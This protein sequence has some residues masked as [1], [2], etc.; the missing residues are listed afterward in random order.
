VTGPDGGGTVEEGNTPAWTRLGLS[1]GAAVRITPRLRAEARVL[2]SPYGWEG[3]RVN[4]FLAGVLW[5]F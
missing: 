2:T 3:E 4:V 1:L 5:T